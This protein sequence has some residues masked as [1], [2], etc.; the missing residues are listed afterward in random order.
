[1]RRKIMRLKRYNRH[2]I[3]ACLGVFNVDDHS[4]LAK[5]L[6]M[7]LLQWFDCLQP[8]V[9]EAS[10]QVLRVARE[11]QAEIDAEDRPAT[12]YGPAARSQVV[13]LF[14]ISEDVAVFMSSSKKTC[15]IQRMTS[16]SVLT[17]CKGQRASPARS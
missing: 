11:Q 9:E 16:G 7:I 13:P 15:K 12:R 3:N 8:L 14:S 6:P 1:M 10:E 2:L 17:G 5:I 4:K